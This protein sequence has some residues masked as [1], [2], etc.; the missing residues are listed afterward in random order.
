M[1]PDEQLKLA[2]DLIRQKEYD[3]AREILVT[4][5]H[6]KAKRW[7]NRLDEL[8]PPVPYDLTPMVGKR[9][10]P[11]DRPASPTRMPITETG[12]SLERIILI[13]VL[14]IGLL[15][16]VGYLMTRLIAAFDEP[17]IALVE[18]N[19]GYG[20]K[21][22]PIRIGTWAKFNGAQVRLTRPMLDATQRLRASDLA[23]II[24]MGSLRYTF[25][26]LEIQCQ[27]QECSPND[28]RVSLIDAAG[29]EWSVSTTL[30]SFPDISPP[31]RLERVFR[32]DTTAGW[33]EFDFPNHVQAFVWVKIE[34][35]GDETLYFKVPPISVLAGQSQARIKSRPASNPKSSPPPAPPH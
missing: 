35:Q 9:T 5:D 18:A 29:D 11:P 3:R 2:A 33:L 25:L 15:G 22:N 23:A 14:A 20:V 16:V 17:T 24:P 1:T 12:I 10:T 32:G 6:P 31:E 7:L 27:Q 13:L 34:W 4:L 28:V 19:N 26:Y 8:V 30:T 21:E